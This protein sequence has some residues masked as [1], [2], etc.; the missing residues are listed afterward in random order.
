MRLLFLTDSFRP[1][2]SACANRACVLVDAMREAGIDVQV[3]ASSDS[4]LGAPEGYVK[5]EYVT[6]F[7]TFP[8]QEKTFVNRLKNNFGGQRASVKVA[9]SMG[10]FDVVV[11]TTPPLLLTTSAM[12]IAKSKSAKLVLDV[13]DVWPDV[14]YEMGSFTPGS[15][16]GTSLRI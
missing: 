10:S 13:R 4:L 5:P 14:A 8:L 16:L 15:P 7:E 11:C 2:R 12:K 1:S 9:Q 6:F 3:L